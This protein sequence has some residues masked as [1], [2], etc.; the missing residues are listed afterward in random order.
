MALTIPKSWKDININ[1]FLQIHAALEMR[2]IDTLDRNIYLAAALINTNVDWVEDNMTLQQI[3]QVIREASFAQEEPKGKVKKYFW[4]NGRLW[5]VELEAK[6]I[7]PAQFFDLS[8]YTKTPQETVDNVAKIMATICRPIFTKY[9]SDKI[10]ARA[11]MFGEKMRF[12]FAYATSL[13]FW[14]L[15][16]KFCDATLTYLADRLKVKTKEAEVLNQ[17]G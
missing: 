13:F 3:G 2:D 5:K 10:E 1:Q 14:A 7:T 17:G 6:N 4:L 16:N 9:D 8:T 15:Y 12:D 11:K